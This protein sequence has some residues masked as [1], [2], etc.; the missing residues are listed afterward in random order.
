MLIYLKMLK[1]YS[2]TKPI[3]IHVTQ[4]LKVG[5]QFLQ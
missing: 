2:Y 4:E 5:K 1:T 3:E